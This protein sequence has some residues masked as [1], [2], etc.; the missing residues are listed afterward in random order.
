MPSAASQ[1]IS[2]MSSNVD[3]LREA[4]RAIDVRMRHGAAGIELERHGLGHP[5][6]A[7]A[8][9]QLV[10]VALRGAREAVEEAVL[11]LEHGARPDEAR[12]REVGGADSRLRRP[13]RVHALGPGAFG[14]VLDDAAGHRAGDA[15]GVHELRSSTSAAPRRRR[16]RAHR[17]RAPRSDGSRPCGSSSARPVLARHISSTPTAMPCS[18][19]LP[20]ERSRSA[21]ARTAG[22]I[23]APAWIGPPSKVSSK[24]SPCAAVPLTNAAPP[25]SSARAWPMRGAAAGS[26]PA[27][28]RGA[29]VVGVARGDA[30]AGDVDHQPLDDFARQLARAR[31][32]VGQLFRDRLGHVISSRRVATNHMVSAPNSDHGSGDDDE[33]A[34]QR[35]GEQPAGDHQREARGAGEH[36]PAARARR[37]ARR[38]RARCRRRAADRT[39]PR[40]AGSARRS[41]A[42]RGRC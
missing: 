1:T 17:A 29:H 39:A 21:T 32:R 26:L 35:N 38:S 25:A 36:R 37:P 3:L 30:Q 33:H 23:T 42:P 19:S 16:R 41:R 27:V 5:A 34:L 14:E 20:G 6:L 12:A 2:S 11:A 4:P 7:E 18:A 15:Q 9:E 40:C 8:V 31:D 10:P 13:A 28:E 24:S 22:T